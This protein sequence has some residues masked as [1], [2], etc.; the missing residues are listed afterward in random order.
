MTR[1]NGHRTQQRVW[2]ET[3]QELEAKVPDVKAVYTMLD[4]M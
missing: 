2:D 4:V 1:Q 3:R